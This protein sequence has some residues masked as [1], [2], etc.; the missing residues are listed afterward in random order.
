MGIEVNHGK[1]A[2][3]MGG[4]TSEREVSLIS[5]K[6]ILASL[7]KSGVDAFSFDPAIAP[8]ATLC[9][10]GCHKA[11]VVIH[12]K[13]GEDGKLQGAL[14]YLRIPYTGSG[15][16]ASAIG[17]DKYR[18]KLIWQSLGVSVAQAQYVTQSSY[19]PANFKLTLSLPVVV[20]PADDGSSFGVSKVYTAD[21]LDKALQ[22]AFNHSQHVLIEPLISGGE[23]TITIVDGKVYPII[24]IEAPDGEYDFEHKY[25]SD[26]TVYLCPYDLGPLQAEIERQ[27]L[28]AYHGVGASGVARLDFMLNDNQQFYFLEINT[29]PGMTNHSLVPQSLA[30][31]GVDFDQLCLLILAGA[32]LDK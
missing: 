11:V 20:K 23:Y 4:N 27:A 2:V 10:L 8:L 12:G 29:L 30:A 28:I 14:E 31:A 15:V 21:H 3:I 32:S 6:A 25:F 19:D 18:T 13:N 16:M 24:K 9:E 5:G 7:L 22:F 17:M 26:E 1:V